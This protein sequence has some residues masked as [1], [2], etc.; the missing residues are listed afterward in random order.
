MEPRETKESISSRLDDWIV[1]PHQE[2][3]EQA[4]SLK[5]QMRWVRDDRN[6]VNAFRWFVWDCLGAG[7]PPSRVEQKSQSRGEPWGK[8]PGQPVESEVPSVESAR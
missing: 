2:T 4:W 8:A 3:V 6:P 7:D 1:D 5:T